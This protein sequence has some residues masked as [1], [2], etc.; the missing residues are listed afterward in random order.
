MEIL[1][2]QL[3]LNIYSVETE[4]KKAVIINSRQSYEDIK[5]LIQLYQKSEDD[6]S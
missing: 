3:P 2:A 4:D 1:F 6:Y 5:E